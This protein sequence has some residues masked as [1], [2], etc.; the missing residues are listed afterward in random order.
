MWPGRAGR[1]FFEALADAGDQGARTL[2]SQAQGFG[3]FLWRRERVSDEMRLV[4]GDSLA[5]RGTR[6]GI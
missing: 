2:G 5:L 4:H 6:V 1:G 3:G